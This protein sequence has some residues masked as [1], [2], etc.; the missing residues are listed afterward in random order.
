MNDDEFDSLLED[1]A[2]TYNVPGDPPRDAM[3]A[4]I[5]RAR[6]EAAV[7]PMRTFRRAPRWI[8]A[9]A[10]VAAVLVIGIAIGRLS[11]GPAVNAVVLAAT[12][13][14]PAPVAAHA[15]SVGTSVLAPR[16]LTHDNAGASTPAATRLAEGRRRP[17]PDGDRNVQGDRG[18][19]AAELSGDQGAYR[20]AVVQHLT[21][22]EILLTGFRAQSQSGH[23]ARVDVQ[24]ATLSRELLGTTRLLLATHR[25]DDPALTRLLQDLELVLMQLSQYA[26]DGHGADLDAINQS[27]DRHNVIPKLRSTI[28]AGVSA[29][30]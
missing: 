14:A 25:G 11:S 23:D 5:S 29:G 19:V 21:R 1:A 3:W 7:T 4:A 26:N 27:L 2:A 9:A 10:G 12:T 8:M 6:E 17:R 22:A 18:S 16:E 20:L 24:F 28:P 13:P 30:T 15:D